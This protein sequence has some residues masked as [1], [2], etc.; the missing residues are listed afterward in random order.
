MDNRVP[1]MDRFFAAVQ[2]LPTFIAGG[3]SCGKD[4][5]SGVCYSLKDEVARVL[6]SLF[7][8]GHREILIPV[9]YSGIAGI[10]ITA[11]EVVHHPEMKVFYPEF[12]ENIPSVW[13]SYWLSALQTYRPSAVVLLSEVH[14][15]S[16]YGFCASKGLGIP[17]NISVV[18]LDHTS[19]MEWMH[20]VP[21]SYLFEAKKSIA[22]FKR[23]CDSTLTLR[24]YRR[25]PMLLQQGGSVKS[26]PHRNAISGDRQ[27]GLCPSI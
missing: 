7:E 20:P 12:P 23:W 22:Y 5:V 6:T 11:E 8:R 14:L 18:C 9:D 13:Q 27:R 21:E 2:L 3:A 4:S 1:V 19:R 24:H 25:I 16:F 10:G 26:I 17:E 15:L